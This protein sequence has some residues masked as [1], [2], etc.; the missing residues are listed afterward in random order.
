MRDTL[1]R[2]SR[3]LLIPLVLFRVLKKIRDVSILTDGA[4]RRGGAFPT[5]DH[6][7]A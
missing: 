3:F 2:Y 6:L 1:R 7:A 4:A 5:P